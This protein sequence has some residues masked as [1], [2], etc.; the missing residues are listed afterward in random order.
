MRAIVE[1]WSRVGW[2][3]AF[4]LVSLLTPNLATA[5]NWIGGIDTFWGTEENWEGGSVPSSGDDVVIPA[6]ASPYPVITSDDNLFV[7]SLAIESGG[8]LTMNDG[9]LVVLD[10]AAGMEVLFGGDFEMNGGNLILGESVPGRLENNGNFRMNS[11]QLEIYPNGTVTNGGLFS[12]SGG[13]IRSSDNNLSFSLANLGTINI[14]SGGSPTLT[15]CDFTNEGELAFQSSSTLLVS[16]ASSIGLSS[17]ENLLNGTLSGSGILEFS[18]SIP[19]SNN[20]Q[21]INNGTISPGGIG[22][23]GTIELIGDL[24]HTGTYKAEIASPGGTADADAIVVQPGV[25]FGGA[26]SLNG[27]LIVEPLA[28]TFSD[29]QVFPIISYESRSGT[30]LSPLDLTAPTG[31][32]FGTPEVDYGAETSADTV[33]L[34]LV[35]ATSDGFVWDGSENS[36]WTNPLNWENGAVFPPGEG[37]DIRIPVVSSPAVYPIFPNSV[38]S[39]GYGTVTVEGELEIASGASFPATLVIEPGGE[40]RNL[41]GLWLLG[42]SY[43]RGGLSWSGGSITIDSEASFTNE[44]GAEIQALNQNTPVAMELLGPFTG[45]F[46]NAGTFA[47]SGA[48]DVRIGV[49]TFENRGI[50]SVSGGRLSIGPTEID[51]QNQAVYRG[52]LQLA[53]DAEIVMDSGRHGFPVPDDSTVPWPVTGDGTVLLK[54]PAPFP[55]TEFP[56]LV[57]EHD[58]SLESGVALEFSSGEVDFGTP[59]SPEPVEISGG[60]KISIASDG[61]GHSPLVNLN[62]DVTVRGPVDIVAGEVTGP[63]DLLLEG[64]FQ[65]TGGILKGP[66]EGDIPAVFLEDASGSSWIGSESGTAAVLELVGRDM[67]IRGEV[68][69]G[70]GNWALGQSAIVQIGEEEPTGPPA[71]FRVE[72][73]STVGMTFTPYEANPGSEY[74]LVNYGIVEGDGK[75]AFAGG[76]SAL[77]PFFENVG[78]IAPGNSPVG[79]L[80]FEMDSYNHSDGQFAVDL[81]G[82]AN[83]EFDRIEFTGPVE[84]GGALSV[85]LGFIPEPG[86]EFRFLANGQLGETRQFD[87]ENLAIG[88]VPESFEDYFVV[89][90]EEETNEYLLRYIGDAPPLALL[91]LAADPTDA[92]AIQGSAAISE[93]ASVSLSCSSACEEYLRVGSAV[94][95][96]ATPSTGYEF[97]RWDDN[98]AGIL[99]DPTANPL[100]FSIQEN[101]SLTAIFAPIEGPT[102]DISIQPPGSGSVSG[103]IA[104][105]PIIDPETGEPVS[106]GTGSAFSCPD[107]CSLSIPAESSVTLTATPN[108]GYEFSGWQ[109]VEEVSGTSAILIMEADRQVTANFFQEDGPGPPAVDPDRDGDGTPD[110]IDGCPD[111]P[112]KIDPGVCGCGEPETDADEDGTPDC[113]DGCPDDPNK[114][115]PGLCGCGV[116][117]GDADEDGTPDCQDECP[118]DPD[119]TEPGVCGCGTPDEDSDAD[120]TLD[121]EDGC[122]EDPDKREP[123]ACGCGIPDTDSDGDGIPDCRDGCPGDPFKTAP[124][125]CGCG[126]SD[127]DSDGDGLPDCQDLCP[128]DPAK[129]TPG[130]CGCGVPETG[131]RDGDG[132]PDCVDRCPDDPAK[133]GPGICGCGIPDTDA[134]GDG[135]PDCRDDPPFTIGEPQALSPEDG[136]FLESPDVTLEGAIFFSG[137]GGEGIETHWWI[138]S[139]DKRCEFRNIQRTTFGGIAKV[140][141]GDLIP[142]LRYVWRF[143]YRD[144]QNGEMVWTDVRTFTIGTPIP[145]SGPEIPPGAALS[146]YQM[147]TFSAWTVAP[148]IVALLEDF[149]GPY[150]TRFFRIGGWDPEA[151]DYLEFTEDLPV[152][153]GRGYWFLAREGL[154]PE[155]QG[156]PLTNDADINANLFFSEATGTGWNQIA[157]PND[158][159]YR[160]GEVELVAFEPTDDP[161]EFE[162]SFGPV[163]LS[164][165]PADNPYIRLE[166]YR[167][168][169]GSYVDLLP[170]E[171]DAVILRGEGYWV[172]AKRDNICLVFRKDAQ[173]DLSAEETLLV[174]SLRNARRFADAHLGPP[175]AI[176]QSGDAPPM[177]MGELGVY[178]GPEPADRVDSGGGG[179]CFIESASR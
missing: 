20:I 145:L 157:A 80:R 140:E 8:E 71:V 36:E 85:A 129:T 35:T 169:E 83:A 149:V 64:P 49:A 177:P 114:T 47:K 84:L 62:S 72:N 133:T 130:A 137:G 5:V 11:G 30:F 59:Q 122:P 58:L 10:S 172:E 103:E 6:N 4:F 154:T 23:I 96:A 18:P 27:D 138:R 65:W 111:D 175:A 42:E 73:D 143:G 15:N 178:S 48:G 22:A 2:F 60:G 67:V 127:V 135:V 89:E 17:F 148:D 68:G 139:A 104:T 144:P 116:S 3:S 117:D 63:G 28:G 70:V 170:G 120:G 163:P 66:S 31:F 150:D 156:V 176:A 101:V 39:Q 76:A 44:A 75:L 55:T 141:P 113:E 126:V 95:L 38:A 118:E 21:L 136:A 108:S 24:I 160:W 121:C 124:G 131:D 25:N 1:R 112:D 109:G 51:G 119:K 168:V 78:A 173:K 53:N 162:R 98:G 94:S 56:Q 158:A 33:T 171:A 87:E 46:L 37:E 179:A 128:G 105:S 69:V 110:R 146:A 99:S 155:F 45:N 97:A 115:E 79:N 134:D 81:L 82:S 161:L 132:A 12:W 50:L 32:D 174:R 125:I 166:L 164:R 107:Q 92:G 13:Q 142:G 153:P 93:G 100:D 165:L 52:E 40:V 123:G 34:S 9:S 57:V 16:D 88:G 151:G 86:Q 26:V 74:G 43:N 19:G 29:G 61:S 90:P 159:D 77:A 54:G 14:S 106:P 102:L 152:I 91:N 147:R 7:N 41:G 167:F